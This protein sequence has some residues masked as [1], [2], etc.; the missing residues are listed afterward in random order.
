MRKAAAESETSHRVFFAI[1]QP[2]CRRMLSIPCST[3]L[4]SLSWVMAMVLLPPQQIFLRP[5]Q[6]GRAVDDRTE[7]Q[8]GEDAEREER[9]V[10]DEKGTPGDENRQE[11]PRKEREEGEEGEARSTGGFGLLARASC[12]NAEAALGVRSKTRV[13]AACMKEGG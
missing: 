6:N 1:S 5:A 4:L 11:E 9:W 13:A 10:D 12:T 7:E 8:E 3:A 2:N